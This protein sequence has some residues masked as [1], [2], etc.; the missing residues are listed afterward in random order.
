MFT[1][2]ELLF[3]CSHSSV[4]CGAA[5]FF[6]AF[7][8]CAVTEVLPTVTNTA[9]RLGFGLSLSYLD[10]A[11]FGIGETSSVS[12]QKPSLKPPDYQNLTMQTQTSFSLSSPDVLIFCPQTILLW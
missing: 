9:D 2:A 1:S 7:L 10:L 12:P 11:L 4:L 8:K 5:Q 6:L 3:T